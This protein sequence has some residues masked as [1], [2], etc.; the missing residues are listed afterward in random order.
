M[1]KKVIQIEKWSS[2]V[3][4]TVEEDIREELK[5]IIKENPAWGWDQLSIQDVFACALNQLPPVYTIKGEKAE[6]LHPI[7]EIR[8]AI[9]IAMKRVESNPI[10]YEKK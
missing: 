4:N 10:H 2:V 8:N 7:E 9:F 6:Y 5:N 3:Q 1:A